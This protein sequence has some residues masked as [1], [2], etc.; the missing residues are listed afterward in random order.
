[1]TLPLNPEQD[2]IVVLDS[3]ETRKWDEY[4]KIW[5]KIIVTPDIQDIDVSGMITQNVSGTNI[6]IDRIWTGTKAAYDN[7]IPLDDTLYLVKD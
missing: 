2:K 1:M 5:K 7:L 3:G 4:K 6:K